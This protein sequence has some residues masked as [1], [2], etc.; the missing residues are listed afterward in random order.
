MGDEEEDTEFEDD[1]DV[2]ELPMP[3]RDAKVNAIEQMKRKLEERL[4]PKCFIQGYSAVKVEKKTVL[5]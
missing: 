4:G 3:L 2:D 5:I 1:E